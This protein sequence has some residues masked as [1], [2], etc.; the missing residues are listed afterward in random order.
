MDLML[1]DEEFRQVHRSGIR[2]IYTIDERWVISKAIAKAAQ[3][4]LVEYIDRRGLHS[5]PI[6][7]ANRLAF[8]IDEEWW[9]KFKKE[10]GLEEG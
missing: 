8:C 6:T 2:Q 1:T 9:G 3:R 5:F 4:K 7:D 10:L